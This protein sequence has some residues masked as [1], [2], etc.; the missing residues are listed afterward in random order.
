MDKD[1]ILKNPGNKYIINGYVKDNPKL[2]KVSF[3]K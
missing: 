2:I 1:V 3:I